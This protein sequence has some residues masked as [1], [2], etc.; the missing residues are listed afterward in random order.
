MPCS[1]RMGRPLYKQLFVGSVTQ[2][3]GFGFLQICL[4]ERNS[5]AKNENEVAY[6]SLWHFKPLWLTFFDGTQ[7]KLPQIS[8]RLFTQSYC[9]TSKDCKC[10]TQ[11]IQTT[12][13]VILFSFFVH[14]GAWQP[15]ATMWFHSDKGHAGFRQHVSKWCW[16][17]GIKLMCAKI[18]SV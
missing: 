6:S 15:L 13:T 12:H 5:S 7:K 4:E 2:G 17:T 16:I 1:K 9:K 3:A 11:V 14:F 18:Q 8:A 10:S